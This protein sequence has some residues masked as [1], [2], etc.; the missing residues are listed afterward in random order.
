M[1]ESTKRLKLVQQRIEKACIDC[2]RA[3][4]DVSLLAVSKRHSV[5]KI[6]GLNK[7][8]VVAFGENHLQEALQKQQELPDL[9]LDWHFI[10]NVQSNKRGPLRRIFNGFKVS[11]DSKFL[12]GYRHNDR[13]TWNPSTFVYRLISILN[14]KRQVRNLKKFCNWPRMLTVLI[15]YG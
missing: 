3:P 15:V 8:G 6:I 2:G 1:N 11:T 12:N 10:G 4:G 13:I 14:H 7:L 9:N 5:E